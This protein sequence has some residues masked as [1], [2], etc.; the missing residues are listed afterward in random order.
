MSNSRQRD[1]KKRLN[2]LNY[3]LKRLELRSGAHD[4]KIPKDVRYKMQQ[5]LNK[6]PRNSSQVRI[7]NRCVNICT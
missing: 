6:L 5:E 4:M 3:E 2:F 1:N 7:K